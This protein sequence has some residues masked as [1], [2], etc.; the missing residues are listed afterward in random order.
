M[1]SVEADEDE[2]VYDVEM[3]EEVAIGATS[4]AESCLSCFPSSFPLFSL[5]SPSKPAFSHP[6][7]LIDTLRRTERAG[8]V[9]MKT[10]K[11]ESERRYVMQEIS[12][13]SK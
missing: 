9:A 10:L 3:L 11:L 1:L 4:V 8:I 12:H 13:K 6:L 2:T 5:T 7:A